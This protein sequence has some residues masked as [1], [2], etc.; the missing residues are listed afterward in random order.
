[1][2]LHH[3]LD[4][5]GIF[6]I[7][8]SFSVHTFIFLMMSTFLCSFLWVLR[9]TLNHFNIS[10]PTVANGLSK[11]GF[12]FLLSSLRY[13]IRRFLVRGRWRSM[14]LIPLTSVRVLSCLIFPLYRGLPFPFF[15]LRTIHSFL[16]REFPNKMIKFMA[17]MPF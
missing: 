1:M 6:K 3:D 10:T 16:P 8:H 4:C 12:V 11:S 2:C 7:I 14:H 13:R 17:E 5:W 9:F 15:F